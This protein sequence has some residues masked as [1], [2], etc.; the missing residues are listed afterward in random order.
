MIEFNPGNRY[1]KIAE[2]EL[3][4][5]LPVQEKVVEDGFPILPGDEILIQQIGLNKRAFKYYALL[6]EEIGGD[7]FF[8]ETTPAQIKGNIQNVTDSGFYPLGYFYVSEVSE[9]SVVVTE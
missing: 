9:R 3:F 5:G 1:S 4:N 6:F 2:D 7:S 8:S